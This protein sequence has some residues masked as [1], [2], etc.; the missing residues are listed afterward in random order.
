MFSCKFSKVSQEKL[1]FVEYLRVSPS[2]LG[3]GIW[4]SHFPKKVAFICF[5][6]SSLKMM[7]NA[8]YFML[9]ALFVLKIF[10]YLS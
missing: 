4:D 1:F 9:K 10:K 2:D 7:R 8:L 6:E 3:F 5:N